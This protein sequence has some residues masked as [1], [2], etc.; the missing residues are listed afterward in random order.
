VAT[1]HLHK[2]SVMEH[3][4]PFMA[5]EMSSKR[6]VG[7][8]DDDPK[9][10][11]TGPIVSIQGKTITT[12]SGSVYILEDVNPEYL[13]WMED[14]GYPYDPENPIKDKRLS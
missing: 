9:Q 12:Y 6:L 1:F 11:I 3:R 7:F 4:D 8:R 14:N 10:V 13:K 2:W 5:P